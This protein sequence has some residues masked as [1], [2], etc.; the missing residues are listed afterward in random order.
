MRRCLLAVVVG[1]V[2]CLVGTSTADS[3]CDNAGI[4][5]TAYPQARRDESV[6]ENL[7]GHQVRHK[8]RVR[9]YATTAQIA[10]PYRWLE[11]PDSN[12]TRAYVASLNAVS[13]PFFDACAPLRQRIEDRLTQMWNF[14]KYGCPS[15]HGRNYFYWHNSGLQN[16]RCV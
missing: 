3:S 9:G 7:F 1:A 8:K 5:V 16:Q 4:D 14:E 10:D 13:R 12:E 2:I 11:Q 6:V 15:K